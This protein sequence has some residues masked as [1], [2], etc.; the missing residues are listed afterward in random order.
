VGSALFC[1]L[2]GVAT[3]AFIGFWAGALAWPIIT[4]RDEE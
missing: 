2:L 4:A 1:W 3:G